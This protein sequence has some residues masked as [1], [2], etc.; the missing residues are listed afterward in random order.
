MRE[1]RNTIL[2]LVSF[3]RMSRK[4]PGFFL[5]FGMRDW[6]GRIDHMRGQ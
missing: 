2:Q 6:F 5:C 4:H 1:M 3:T